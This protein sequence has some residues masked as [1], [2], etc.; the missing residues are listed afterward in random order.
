MRGQ[1]VT[2]RTLA[3]SASNR[4]D[5]AVSIDYQMMKVGNTWRVFDISTDGVSLVRNYRTQFNRIIERDGWD[6][7][8]ARMRDRL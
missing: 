3:S 4:R 5:P 1:V 2:V 8:I 6:A 7:L